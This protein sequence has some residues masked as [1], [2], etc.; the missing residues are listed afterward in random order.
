[1][2]SLVVLVLLAWSVSSYR[3]HKK[4]MVKKED[5]NTV[6][7]MAYDSNGRLK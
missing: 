6:V 5:P 7:F 3:H 2:K 4:R 1:M